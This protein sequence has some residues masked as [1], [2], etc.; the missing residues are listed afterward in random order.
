M[1]VRAH[2]ESAMVPDRGVFVRT[3]TRWFGDLVSR[4]RSSPVFRAIC[5]RTSIPRWRRLVALQL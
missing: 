3:S 4:P 1:F 5:T 2:L